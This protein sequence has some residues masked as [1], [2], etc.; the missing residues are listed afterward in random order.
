MAD[1]RLSIPRASSSKS[2]YLSKDD[3]ILFSGGAAVAVTSFNTRTGEVILLEDDVLAA[4]GYA[5][6]SGDKPFIL[7]SG[8]TMTGPLQL[9]PGDPPSNA[10][11]SRAYV[12]SHTGSGPGGAVL[13]G[14]IYL[15]DFNASG[16]PATYTGT[17]A[18]GALTI[19]TVNV[20]TDFVVGQGIFI[21]NAGTGG[22]TPFITTVD[23]ISGTTITLH[24]AA[25]APVTNKRVQH[26]DTDAWQ[27]ALNAMQTALGGRLLA[28]AGVFKVNKPTST[29]DAILQLPFNYSSTP[30]P[31]QYTHCYS[32]IGN[33]PLVSG[34]YT[35]E[36]DAVQAT[37]IE[38][39][40]RNAAGWIMSAGPYTTTYGY[41]NLAYIYI[42][43]I[44]FRTYDDPEISCLDL[45]IVWSIALKGVGCDTGPGVKAGTYPTHGTIGVRLPMV[46]TCTMVYTELLCVRGY[47]IGVVGSELWHSYFTWVEHCGIGWQSHDS[48][49]NYPSYGDILIGN[50]SIAIKVKTRLI[51]DVHLQIEQAAGGAY[52]EQL[53]IQDAGNNLSGMVRYYSYGIGIVAPVPI[54][55]TGCENVTIWSLYGFGIKWGKQKSFQLP[56]STDLQVHDLTVR[57]KTLLNDGAAQEI[58]SF[59][60]ADSG[61]SGKRQAIVPNATTTGLLTGLVSYWKFD[62]PSGIRYDQTGVCNL[63]S[64]SYAEAAMGA[65][66]IGNCL[67]GTAGYPSLSGPFKGST[68]LTGSFS[69][70]GW[71]NLT[72]LGSYQPTL[73]YYDGAAGNSFLLL[74]KPT[75]DAGAFWVSF[76]GGAVVTVEV[77]FTPVVGTWYFLAGVYDASTNL[78]KISLNGAA[79]VTA[80]TGTT[81][82]IHAPSYLT[83]LTFAGNAANLKMDE[84]GLW[85]R[86]LTIGDVGALYAGGSGL[87]YPF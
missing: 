77:P 46:N 58:V 59:G 60:T 64:S 70:T 82:A 53:T 24:D 14:D 10:A 18:A 61:G 31:T 80:P 28:G 76:T 83:A 69:V 39:E 13:A 50:C 38:T 71:I 41:G 79:F 54:S 67:D 33:V 6:I 36:P 37:I 21:E 35:P 32:V 62:E 43:N 52:T 9:P 26:D 29:W 30:G 51:V 85:S 22:T 44:V 17:I 56:P 65:G 55:W 49:A 57:G 84:F 47:G 74:H 34:H 12:D 75:P 2:G 48:P 1:R 5:P 7:K 78:I 19:L 63:S 20:A 72:A 40:V 3:F 25:L 86:A 27:A 16:S 42:E 8:D 73:G 68:Y 81:G 87:A 11:A 66:K 15:S 45:T 4:L 23:A